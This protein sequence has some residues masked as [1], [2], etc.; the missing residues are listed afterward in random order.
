MLWRL[1]SQKRKKNLSKKNHSES[2]LNIRDP[3][4]HKM[5][6]ELISLMKTELDTQ[7]SSILDLRRGQQ[8]FFLILVLITLQSRVIFAMIQNL[9][10]KRM[11]SQF[12]MQLHCS[13]NLVVKT[14]ENA[15]QPHSCLKN[16]NLL[17]D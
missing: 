6:S 15:N 9:V 16:L 11:T 12:L 7:E 17:K 8:R 2:F 5:D 10:S 1:R 4:S 14:S 13:T 3:H